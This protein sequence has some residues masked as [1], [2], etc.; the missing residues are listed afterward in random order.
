MEKECISHFYQ[1]CDCVNNK[2]RKACNM[3]LLEHK[4]LRFNNSDLN[5]ESQCECDTCKMAREILIISEQ[6]EGI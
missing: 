6:T 5:P 4:V 1:V 3:F 2:I